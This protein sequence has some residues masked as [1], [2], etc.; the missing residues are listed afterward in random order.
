MH[1]NMHYFNHQQGSALLRNVYFFHVCFETNK[2]GL[3]RNVCF[4]KSVFK[5]INLNILS[6]T[7]EFV[8]YF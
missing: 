5:E 3:L 2:C 8:T 7:I 4:L 6:N 1:G